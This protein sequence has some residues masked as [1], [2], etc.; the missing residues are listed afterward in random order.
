MVGFAI[1]NNLPFSL[2]D[3]ECGAG[4]DSFGFYDFNYNHPGGS[5]QDC[6][7][8]G[9]YLSE[10]VNDPQR[11]APGEIGTDLNRYMMLPC[12]GGLLLMANLKSLDG[13]TD[14]AP[15]GN[16]D[17]LYGMDYFILLE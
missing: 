17:T 2:M 5:V 6:L 14:N 11:S 8:N 12:N 7:V 1:D 10:Q 3:S 13:P 9:G 15:C 4:G 16:Y